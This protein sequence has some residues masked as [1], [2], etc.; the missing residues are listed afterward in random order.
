M[1]TVFI[2]LISLLILLSFLYFLGFRIT[3]APTLA[4]N[5]NAITAVGTWASAL[6]PL[7]LAIINSYFALKIEKTKKEISISNRIVYETFP[8]NMETDLEERILNYIKVSIIVSTKSIANFVGKDVEDVYRV[9]AKMESEKI[10]EGINHRKG[11]EKQK[12]IWKSLS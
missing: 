7:F 4:N 2:V 8:V 9:L 12:I 5:W 1:K 11:T 6:S 3:Y 10:I